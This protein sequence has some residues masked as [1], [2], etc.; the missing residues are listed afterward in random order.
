VSSVFKLPVVGLMF[1][2]VV[3]LHIQVR[4]SILRNLFVQLIKKG[5]NYGK[6]IM[7]EAIT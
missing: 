1:V 2:I 3:L 5:L 6:L 7:G 4:G